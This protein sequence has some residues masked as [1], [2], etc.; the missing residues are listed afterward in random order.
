MEAPTH[1]WW[2]TTRN[3]WRRVGPHPASRPR[4]GLALGGGFA[5]G[6][7]HI[8][9]LRVFEKHSIPIDFIA[10]VSSGS[11]VSTAY[12]SGAT[13]S[14]IECMARA[15]KFSHVARWTLN[16]LG[17]AHSDRMVSFC[18][19]LLKRT[20]FEDMKIPC[21]IVAT[22]LATGRPVVFKDRGEV[23]TPIRASCAFP[24]LFQ[25][26]RY[27]NRFLVDGFVAMEVPA[28]PLRKMGATHVISVNLPSPRESV[29]PT[30]LFSVIDRCFQAMSQR[31]EHE[32][33]ASS[34]VI[35]EPDVADIGWDSFNSANRLLELGE[36][37][38]LAALPRIQEWL[39]PRAQKEKSRR[40]YAPTLGTQQHGAI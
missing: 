21:A 28:E 5:R 1:N 16:R 8:G 22:D 27:Q 6:I 24:G 31:L 7:A 11:I 15:M 35:I 32:W 23:I 38:A 37:A 18:G 9:V 39:K 30:S 20:R 10:G 36:Q 13:T 3:W 33:R 12:A 19:R 2:R 4:I 17:L 40:L 34:D 25:P 29:D 14:D 26:L